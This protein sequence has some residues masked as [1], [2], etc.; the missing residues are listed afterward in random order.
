[1]LTII[2]MLIETLI[3]LELIPMKMFKECQL[4][5]YYTMFIHYDV[6]TSG[7]FNC[8]LFDIDKSNKVSDVHM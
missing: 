8:N 7:D 6:I 5:R 1:M 2:V 4:D 3:L